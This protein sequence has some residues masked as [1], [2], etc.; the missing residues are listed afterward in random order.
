MSLI[1][2]FSA[3]RFHKFATQK[4]VDRGQPRSCRMAPR[5]RLGGRQSQGR[6][7]DRHVI[8]SDFRKN[9]DMQVAIADELRPVLDV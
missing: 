1:V 4:I 7:L 2:F 3:G 9:Q 5:S 8:Y 6:Q